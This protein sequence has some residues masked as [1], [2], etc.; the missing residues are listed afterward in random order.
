MKKFF[1]DKKFNIFYSLL[2]VL[3]MWAVW[4]I[5]CAVV[6]NEYLVPDFF[7]S[8]REFFTL[9]AKGFFW[10]SLGWSMLRVIIAFLLSFLLALGCACLALVFKPF[11]AFMR[12]IVA[13]FRTLPT[14]A[15]LLIILVW[16]TPRTAP[17]AVTFLVLFPMIYTQLT[18]GIEGV[19]GGL[20][21]M[22]KVYRLTAKQKLT[23][24]Y[25]PQLAPQTVE[26]TGTNL[27]FGL[28]LTISAEVM[29][30]TYTALGG[31]MTEAQAYM[32]LPRLTALTL[33]SVIFGVALEIVFR[34][35]SALP[36]SRARGSNVRA[37]R[38][39]L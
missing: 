32:N 13:F 2:A 31:M 36:Y 37:W 21:Q 23:C 38:S 4:L 22:A 29:A 35:L 1:T 12:P 15:V 14:M 34:L 6:G 3:I 28:K 27:S 25:L 10:K 7:S 18:L 24:I 26:Q 39:E 16:M 11:S 17:V 9:F 5:V 19:D 8:A 30:S 20:L 33:V